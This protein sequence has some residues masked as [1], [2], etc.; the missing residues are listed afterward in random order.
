M[1][2]NVIRNKKLGRRRIG[3]KVAPAVTLRLPEEITSAVDAWGKQHAE[4]GKKVPR[5]EAIRRL[6]ELGLAK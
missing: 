2:R 6:I 4:P 5:S 3:K 1:S